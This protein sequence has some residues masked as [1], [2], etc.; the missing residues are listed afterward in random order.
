MPDVTP[1]LGD[2]LKDLEKR[3]EILHNHVETI[4]SYTSPEDVM[5]EMIKRD[6]FKNTIDKAINK[7][8][9]MIQDL[10]KNKRDLRAIKS[11]IVSDKGKMDAYRWSLI[12]ERKTL[13]L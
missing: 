3:S 10:K 11:I 9:D 12:H 2:A 8:E 4:L 13:N 7:L 1:S 6:E 5:E